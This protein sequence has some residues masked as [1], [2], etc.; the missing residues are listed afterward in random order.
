P[1]GGL[2]AGRKGD[3]VELDAG[4]GELQACRRVPAPGRDRRRLAVAAEPIQDRG[5]A[6][7]LERVGGRREGRVEEGEEARVQRAE[8]LRADGAI[9]PALEELLG[10]AAVRDPAA[11]PSLGP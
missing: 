1:I 6:R 8:V 5:C 2:V 11:G 9:E 3:P 7:D 10:D 4:A